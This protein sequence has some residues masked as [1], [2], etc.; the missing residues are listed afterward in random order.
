MNRFDAYAIAALILAGVLFV[1]ARRVHAHSQRLA[2][3]AEHAHAHGDE[4]EAL[5]IVVDA[6][7]AMKIALRLMTVS[8]WVSQAAIA[9][10]VYANTSSLRLTVFVFCFVLVFS[11]TNAYL[12][13]KAREAT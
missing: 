3:A 9:S 1:Q 2:A 8:G 6:L 11:E 10:A 5:I 7:S 12:R 13:K 4:S